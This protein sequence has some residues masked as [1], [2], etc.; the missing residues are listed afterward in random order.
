MFNATERAK[1]VEALG[2]SDA[3]FVELVVGTQRE[4]GISNRKLASDLGLSESTVS[5]KLRGHAKITRSDRYALA[6][7][8]MLEKEETGA[9]GENDGAVQVRKDPRGRKPSHE[10]LIRRTRVAALDKLGCNRNEI[11]ELLGA[12]TKAS[13]VANDLSVTRKPGFDAGW[14]IGTHEEE[15]IQVQLEADAALLPLVRQARL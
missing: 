13:S 3:G 14:W 4:L 1:F 12:D 9:R 6:G 15:D 7:Y 2:G 10:V 11:V 8:L 5:R